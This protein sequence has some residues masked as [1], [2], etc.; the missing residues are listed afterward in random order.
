VIK[1]WID[2]HRGIVIGVCVALGL[3]LLLAI[4]RCAWLSYQRRRNPFA[5]R[6]M[7]NNAGGR[8]GRSSTPVMS[9]AAAA[10]WP[11]KREWKKVG[12]SSPASSSQD[13]YTPREQPTL[14]RV[15][16]GSSAW[17]YG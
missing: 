9:G 1:S 17:R 13:S 12:P 5:M 10:A 3:L 16:Y 8:G 4:L 14:P 6:G 2:G 15:D 11:G 7:R